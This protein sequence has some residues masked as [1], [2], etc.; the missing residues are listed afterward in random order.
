MTGEHEEMQYLNLVKNILE[1]GFVENGR[2]GE[3]ISK[4]G[5]MMRF[6]LKDG[7]LPLLTTKKV[8]WKSCAEELFWFIRGST[9]VNELKQKNVHIWNANSTRQF[10]DET[11]LF[12]LQEDDIGPAYGHQWRHFNA[13]YIDNKTDYTGKGIDQLVNIVNMLK[14]PEMRNSRRIIMSSWNPCQLN[15]MALPPCHILCQFNVRDNKY[16]SC[17]VY[18][19]SCDILLGVPFNIASYSLLTHILAK[20]CNLEADEFIHFLGNCH[21]YKEHVEALKEQ[22]LRIPTEP[23]PK[24]EIIQKNKMEEYN[25]D[26]LVWKTKY[27]HQPPI[28]SKM[29]V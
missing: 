25:L 29:I 26:C 22:I 4:F 27:N 2:N 3:T 5:N 24:I 21:I 15:E 12:H 8:A 11:N 23:F 1:T 16:L 19:R 28:K 14:N 6:S 13:E 9:D 20:H 7:Q 10:L 18:Q 17:A